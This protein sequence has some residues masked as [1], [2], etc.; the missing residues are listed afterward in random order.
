MQPL[1]ESF[2]THGAS[3]FNYTG[4]WPL[5]VMN[6]FSITEVSTHGI[7]LGGLMKGK[8]KLGLK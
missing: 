3:G 2:L 8:L 5:G 4:I 6:A 7:M 1:A